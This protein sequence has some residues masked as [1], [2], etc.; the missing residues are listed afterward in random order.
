MHNE[1]DFGSAW[2]FRQNPN[3]VLPSCDDRRTP[4]SLSSLLLQSEA[5]VYLENGLT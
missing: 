2:V 3:G 1:E 4:A 5:V